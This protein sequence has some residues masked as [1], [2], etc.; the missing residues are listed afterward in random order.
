M[1]WVLM[2]LRT[3]VSFAQVRSLLHFKWSGM[4]IGSYHRWLQQTVCMCMA[5]VIVHQHTDAYHRPTDRDTTSTM[6]PTD[7]E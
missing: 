1:V 2:L 3:N 7:P 6:R 4:L 5:C